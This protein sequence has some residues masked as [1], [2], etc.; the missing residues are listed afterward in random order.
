MTSFI[1]C[2][3]RTFF[4]ILQSIG[5][6]EIYCDL[7]CDGRYCIV[8]VLCVSLNSIVSW[9]Y[10]FQNFPQDRNVTSSFYAEILHQCS[11][12]FQFVLNSFGDRTVCIVYIISL[13]VLWICL[14]MSFGQFVVPKYIFIAA[15]CAYVS[16]IPRMGQ[17][18][19]PLRTRIVG[20]LLI[21]LKQLSTVLCVSCSK[22]ISI[23]RWL[24]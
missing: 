19:I 16:F 23:L 14:Q 5:S 12:S 3:S 21:Y 8:I 15:V 13:F 1:R 24:V 9:R 7:H 2:P 18:F 4:K 10:V 20:P 11:I 22:H 17:R 6:N